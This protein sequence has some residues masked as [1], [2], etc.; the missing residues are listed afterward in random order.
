MCDIIE[1]FDM[2]VK[3]WCSKLIQIVK[4]SI[5]MN[6]LRNLSTINIYIVKEK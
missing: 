1:R 3:K 4:K 2:K 6:K 5:K